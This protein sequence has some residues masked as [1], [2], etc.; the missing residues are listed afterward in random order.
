MAKQACGWC[1]G[2]GFRVSQSGEVH[3]CAECDG[4]GDVDDG[5]ESCQ[6]CGG[7]LM[8]LGALGFKLWLVCLDCGL[9]Q[10]LDISAAS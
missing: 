7:E 5:R 2:K 10:S 1:H 9:E 8:E 4:T 3:A 6:F